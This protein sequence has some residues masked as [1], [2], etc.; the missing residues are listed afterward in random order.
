MFRDKYKDEEYFRQEFKFNLDTFNEFEEMKTGV[1]KNKITDFGMVQS[2]Y[3]YK[4]VTMSYSLGL[5][6]NE[7]FKWFKI[8]LR[9]FELSY[10]VYGSTYDLID[11]LSL[12]V[13]FEDR[14]AEF[15]E[16][17]EKIFQKYLSFVDAGD[18]LQ[19]DYIDFLGMYL[20]HDQVVNFHSRLE[21]LN[22]MGD[23]ADSV[24]EAQKFWYYAHS[25]AAWY[26]THKSEDAYYGY[27]SFDTAALC[28]IRGIYDERL[29]EL[30]Y[31]PYDLLVQ[32]DD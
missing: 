31:F 17:I 8:S 6:F 24:I 10:D 13:L 27:W 15:I 19:D 9:Y 12:A 4:L 5:P 11:Y 3:S 32:K 26:D 29:K 25:E 18:Q 28:K 14:K 23:T 2:G 7:I 1:N 20:L 22:L 21:Y 16:D 30:D